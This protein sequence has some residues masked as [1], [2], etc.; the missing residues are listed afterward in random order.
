M[1]YKDYVQLEKGFKTKQ[2]DMELQLRNLRDSLSEEQVRNKNL[3]DVVK[4]LTRGHEAE[5]RA[6]I[7]ELTKQNSILE[8]N[9]MRLT[10]KY[11]TLA[12]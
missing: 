10:R 12:E 3:E 7:V 11:Q 2:S 9:M 5:I 1:L 4:T 6:R 8:V